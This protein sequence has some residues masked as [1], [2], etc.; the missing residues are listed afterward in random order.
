[1]C[2]GGGMTGTYGA[3]PKHSR[4][5]TVPAGSR[6]LGG[7]TNKFVVDERFAIRIPDGFPLELAGPIMC[8]AW[9]RGGNCGP[10][11]VA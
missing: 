11:T 9:V 10:L 4:S 2:S 7:Y 6:T 1:M 5:A 8:C 3:K